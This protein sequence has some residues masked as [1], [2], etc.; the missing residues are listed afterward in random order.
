MIH[1]TTSC[2]LRT[3]WYYWIVCVDQFG[4]EIRT[5]LSF[6]F[7]CFFW[8]CLLDGPLC[9]VSPPNSKN[10]LI[11]ISKAPLF[12]FRLRF[13]FTRSTFLMQILIINSR[14]KVKMNNKILSAKYQ[15][16]PKIYKCLHICTC[17]YIRTYSQSFATWNTNKCLRLVT[18]ELVH[19]AHVLQNVADLILM[20]TDSFWF[21]NYASV[22]MYACVQ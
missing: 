8:F 15:E 18:Y 11:C 6:F 17:I 1:F 5:N 22:C 12:L 19:K 13:E 9:T 3:L 14:C 20:S 2:L 7:F 10:L 16:R 4:D 21:V